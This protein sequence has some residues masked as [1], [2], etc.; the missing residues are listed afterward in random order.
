M[1]TLGWVFLPLCLGVG[2]SLRTLTE[3]TLKAAQ[4]VRI[5]CTVV[6]VES[7]D[8]TVTFYSFAYS[9]TTSS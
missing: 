7:R 6:E 4:C 9:P 8:D 1:T 2:K 3:R 5:D